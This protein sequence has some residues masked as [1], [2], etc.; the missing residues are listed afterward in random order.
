LAF[1]QPLNRPFANK[2]DSLRN[3]GNLKEAIQE[4]GRLYLQNPGN[5]NILYNYACALSLFGQNDS[6]IKYL[7]VYIGTDTTINILTDPD[8]CPLRRDQRWSEIENKVVDLFNIK[9]NHPFKNPEFAKALW[10]MRA[11]DQFGFSEIDI[12]IK[13]TG[14][15]SSVVRGIW[16]CKFIIGENTH[17]ELD[18][19]ITIYGWPRFKD[20][21]E[22]A[23]RTAF[24]VILHS[25][26]RL[27]NKY[28][29]TVKV[30]CE[31]KELPW[32]RYATMYDRSLWYEKKPQKYGT[33]TQ[34]NPTTQKEEVYPLEDPANVDKWRKELGLEP[35]KDYLARYH[36]N[37]E[38]AGNDNQ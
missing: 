4:Y 20:V 37:Y 31:E 22:Q 14:P 10:R 38:P 9:Y 27:I 21:G 30:I 18:K 16:E 19:L 11:I 24:T 5:K 23:A 29:P 15:N 34:F 32:E 33:H 7:N 13:K 1:S 35:L 12:A 8:F 2:A 17:N 3:E 6:C 25:N 28:L 36:I 26:S